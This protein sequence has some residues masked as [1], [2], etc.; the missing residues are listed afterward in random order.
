MTKRESNILKCVAIMLMLFHH[1]FMYAD[2]ADYPALIY[3]PLL[4]NPWRLASAGQLSKLCVTIFVFITAYG[5]ARSYL[6]DDMKDCS[7]LMEKSTRRLVKLLVNFQFVYIIAAL[8]CPLSGKNWLTLYSPSRLENL[9]FALFDFMG[10]SF[11]I[12]TPSYNSSWWYMS[13]A[14]TFVLTLPLLIKLCRR[15]GFFVLLPEI[16][17]VRWLG[18]E[19]VLFRYLLITLLGIVLAEYGTVERVK[20]WYDRA[21]LPVKAGVLLLCLGVTGAVSVLWLRAGD[22]LLDIYEALLCLPVSLLTLLVPG[23]IPYV[24]RAAEFVGRHSM[25]MF[26]IHAF[27]YQNWFYDFTYSLKYPALIYLFLFAS[28]LAASVL[29]EQLKK[30]LRVEELT[31]WISNRLCRLLVRQAETV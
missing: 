10:V 1:L 8:L 29:I 14:V 2:Q 28:S 3:G 15:Y 21:M 7:R 12:N 18:V 23:R 9:V 22:N 30:W 24:N 19:F 20:D 16:L 31:R 25:N 4:S 17:L 11:I 26:F 13:L 27:I 6:G 5:T